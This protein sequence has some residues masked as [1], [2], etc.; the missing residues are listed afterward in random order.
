MRA[1]TIAALALLAP[2]AARAQDAAELAK[3]LTTEGAATFE[4]RNAHA[5]AD[6][7]LDD[8]VVTLLIKNAQSGE[9]KLDTRQGR[10]AIEALYQDLFKDGKPVQAKN[11][12]ESAR[13][14]ESDVLLITGTFEIVHEG[15]TLRLQFVQVRH[16]QG[17]GWKIATLQVLTTP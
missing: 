14:L 8:A 16:Q 7:Y 15:N 9:L 10:S 13:F 3:K 6:S 11:T 1:L 17:G 4:T 5:M 12:V 2:A